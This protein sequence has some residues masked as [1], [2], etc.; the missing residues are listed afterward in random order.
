M[1]TFQLYINNNA[2]HDISETLID[3]KQLKTLDIRD[4]PW[5]CTCALQWLYELIEERQHYDP[6]ANL[7]VRWVPFSNN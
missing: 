6:E 1:M 4:N 5:N 7:G 2:L 3:W